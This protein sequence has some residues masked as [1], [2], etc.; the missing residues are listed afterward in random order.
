[1]KFTIAPFHPTIGTPN[2]NSSAMMFS[3][4]K[5]GERVTYKSPKGLH[6]GTSEEKVRDSVGVLAVITV[7]HCDPYLFQVCV[8][9]GDY[10]CSTFNLAKYQ[11]RAKLI[12][13]RFF[14]LKYQIS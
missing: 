7:G 1:M 3:R 11:L 4:P 9:W 12:P 8:A 10:S 5:S 14:M 2:M 6:F 13:P